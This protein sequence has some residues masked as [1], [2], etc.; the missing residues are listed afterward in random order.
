MVIKDPIQETQNNK[1][2]IYIVYL[3]VTK[4]YDKAWLDAIMYVLYKEGVKDNTWT[5]AKKLCENLTDTLKTQ[6]H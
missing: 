6:P 5:I 4:A 2:P 1:K 3:D